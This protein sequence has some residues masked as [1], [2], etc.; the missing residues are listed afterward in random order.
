MSPAGEAFGRPGIRP[1]WSAGD[2]DIVASALGASRIWMTV[3]GGVINEIFWPS[4]GRPQLRD[5]GFLVTGDD[6]WAEVKREASYR[7]STP[8]PAVPLPRIVHTHDRYRLTIDLVV[9]PNRDAVVV[10]YRLE[11]GPVA[12]GNLRLHVLAAPHLAGTGWGNSAWVDDSGLLAENDEECLAIVDERG[13]STR[14]A[15]FVG[16]SDG[17][18][19]ISNHG[20]PQWEFATATNGNVALIGTFIDNDG[21]FAI[22]FATTPP[23][24]RGLARAALAEGFDA[25]EAQFVAGWQS[26]ATHLRLPGDG[27]DPA[28]LSLAR[29][30]AMVVKVHEDTNFPGAVVASLSTPW[31]VAHDDP[32]GYHLVWPRDCAETGLALGAIGCLDDARRMLYFLA[33]NQEPDGHWAQNFSASG[34][35]Y[36]R[37]IQLDET[38]LP[39]ILAVKLR[40]IG[41]LSGRDDD[42]ISTMVRRACGYL[43]RH[44]PLTD[45]DRWEE[46]AGANPFTLAV[47]VTALLAAGLSG[48]LGP[49]ESAY[50]ISLADWWNAGIES[51]VYVAATR[52]DAEMGTAGHYVRVRPPDQVNG[53]GDGRVTLANRDGETI[54]VAEL[55]GLEFLA[56]VRHGLR[57]AHDPRI[58]DSVRMVDAILRRELE[59]GPYFYRYQRDGYGE[60]ADGAP[61]DGRGIGRLWPL[62]AGERGNY[63][64]AAGEDPAPYLR[65]MAGSASVGGM[66]PEQVWD[67][68]PIA[69]RRLRA[70]RATGSAAPLVWAH[71]EFLKL[72][73]FAA[74]GQPTDRIVAVA[75]H[76]AQPSDASVAH[77]R[78]EQ[79]VV[80]SAPDVVVE[81]SEPFLLHYG[82]NDWSN[83]TDATS[84]PLGFAMHGVRINRVALGNPERIVYTRLDPTSSS[85]DDLDRTITW[86]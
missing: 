24:A 9:D 13:F 31:G 86:H 17:W 20:A 41:A 73:I 14:S 3:G 79:S 71:A 77:V 2:K 83:P 35:P 8:D 63:A 11:S 32:G 12:T 52:Y 81:R 18:Q 65:A 7:L 45:Q 46:A 21:C 59:A 42:H 50:A 29:T 56:L 40:E 64:V 66:I 78:D 69:A 6:F 43:V 61:F 39:I 38:A 33:A 23:G 30:S 53:G 68:D 75:A 72:A 48:W 16:A 76:C 58:V 10:R 49:E 26:W 4:T 22:G 70:G 82:V 28:I 80:I 1:A 37:G 44:G 54:E 55:V 5:L 74:T 19:D 67:A 60:H 25:L 84:E 34:E 51:L 47:T 85:W 15:G 27:V 62:L 57:D 36:W